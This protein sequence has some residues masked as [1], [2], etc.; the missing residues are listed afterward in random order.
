M[1][2]VASRLTLP[3]TTQ[4]LPLVHQ[5]AIDEF[6][7]T[8]TTTTGLLCSA[9]YLQDLRAVG[10]VS[11][12]WQLAIVAKGI[13][14]SATTLSGA[15]GARGFSDR[16]RAVSRR[17][18]FVCLLSG[19]TSRA[20]ADLP[21]EIAGVCSLPLTQRFCPV[22]VEHAD[23][24]VSRVVESEAY[25]ARLREA[26]RQRDC[27]PHSS[28]QAIL[29]TT[30]SRRGSVDHND[31]SESLMHQLSA[32]H[33]PTATAASA[34]SGTAAASVWVASKGK[35][36]KPKQR[37]GSLTDMQDMLKRVSMSMKKVDHPTK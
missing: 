4:K 2:T 26:W 23:L 36:G 11:D 21:R 34:A 5:A 29:L 24:F 19:D 25:L 12:D 13:V 8:S 10:Q 14:V 28:N 9:F 35:E 18:V 27:G 33:G 1:T 30:E 15:F 17:P 16:W 6:L 7:E 37:R 31:D 3:S 32:K 20:R 22:L